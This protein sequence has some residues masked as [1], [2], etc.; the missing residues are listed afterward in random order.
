MRQEIN[1]CERT[2]LEDGR[3]G[4]ETQAECSRTRSL[5]TNRRHSQQ[6]ITRLLLPTVWGD[7]FRGQA[8]CLVNSSILVRSCYLH[9]IVRQMEVIHPNPRE[10]V[11][12]GTWVET[13][14]S[15]KSVLFLL[16]SAQENRSFHGTHSEPLH[17]NQAG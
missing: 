11:N 14:V 12:R 4:I 10:L 9:P 7:V 1:P 13:H 15:G 3:T 17:R 8:L 6:E 16:C 2:C 5:A